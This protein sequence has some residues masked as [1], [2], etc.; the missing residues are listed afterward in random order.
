M[1]ILY[2]DLWKGKTLTASSEAAGYPGVN[3]QHAHL[4][5]VWRTTGKAAEWIKIN[6][7]AAVSADSIAI[8]AHNLSASAVVKVQGNAT[9]SWATPALDRNGNPLDPIIFVPFTLQSLQWWRVYIEDTSN[10]ASY[11]Q[12][13]RVFLCA[14]WEAVEYI[15]AGFK[16]NVEDS[17]IFV[18]SISGQR[19]SDLGTRRRVYSFSMGTMKDETKESLE[20]IAA[21]ARES[22]PVIVEPADG[23]DRLYATM[24]QPVFTQAGG[25]CWTDGGLEFKEAL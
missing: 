16:P 25:W 11:L 3:T 2:G 1:R 19:F 4:S 15:D 24:K 13:G 12:V 6:A 18:E 10:P 20:T 14:R 17:S 8:V 22:E 21:S 7:S 9:D 5:K 23:I